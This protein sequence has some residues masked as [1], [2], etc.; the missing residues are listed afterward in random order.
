MTPAPAAAKKQNQYSGSIQEPAV[1]Q[2]ASELRWVRPPQQ[3]RSQETLD[4]ILDAAEALI[5]EKSFEDTRVSDVVALAGS[6]VGAFY[7]RFRDKEGL[8]HA[9]YDRFLAEATATAD[10]ALD[11]ERWKGATIPEILG[12]VI[13]FLVTV[14][15]EQGGLLR[16][17]VLRNRSDAEFGLRQ[18]R[19]SHYVSSR[20]CDLLLARRAQIAHP[21]P[22]RAAHFGFMVVFSTLDSTM[23]FGETYSSGLSFSDDEVASELTRNYLA[24]LGVASPFH[25][26]PIRNPN[27]R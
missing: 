27:A 19:L 13:R 20:L 7:A 21:D 17:F 1:P 14:F 6:S 5:A 4:R 15:R 26:P 25:K 3:T 2:T 9:L 24:Y 8:L 23:L 18:A 11:P 10:A 16:S 22:Q 12:S